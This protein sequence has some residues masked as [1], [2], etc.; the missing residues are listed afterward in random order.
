ML[1]PSATDI[2]DMNGYATTT[3][4]DSRMAALGREMPPPRRWSARVINWIV[5]ARSHRVICLVLGIWLL[6][7]FDLAF[8]ILSHDQGMLHE[9][10]PLA[11][12]MLA[13]GTTS[14]VLF[15]IGLV[16]TGSYPLLRF[17]T[18]R[19]TEMGAFVILL[20]YAVL[21][22]HWSECYDLYSSTATHHMDL[23]E[24]RLLSSFNTP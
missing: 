8:T 18:A 23:A 1:C 15:K 13:Y 7:G 5:E 21:A 14:I 24:G 10:N 12:H 19:I 4:S 11:R 22:L 2:L 9:E 20:A 16:L 17:R 6:N 3:L